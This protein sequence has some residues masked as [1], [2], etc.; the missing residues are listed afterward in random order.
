MDAIVLKQFSTTGRFPPALVLNAD[1]RPL[2]YFPLSLWGWQDVVK[3]VFLQR[4]DIVQKY[5]CIISSPSYQFEL[6][7]V[8]ALKEY[9]HQSRNPVF[10]RF[11]VFLRDKFSCQYC[12]KPFS[13]SGLTFDHVIPRSKGG[14]TNWEN[15]VAAC[16][17]CN[18]YKANK[19][20]GKTGINP[21][22]PPVKPSSF[23]LQENGRKFP[24]NHL[25]HTWTDYLYWDVELEIDDTNN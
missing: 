25:H 15:V 24:P 3:A 21:V 4:V 11:N 19:M 10:T 17:G 18:V 7:S 16:T 20:P 13:A 6:P 22:R 12:S 14:K 9:V 2:N 5:E 1:Y 8:I 23:Q